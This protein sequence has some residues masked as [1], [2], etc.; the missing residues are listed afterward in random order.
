MAV[1]QLQGPRPWGKD[2][3]EGFM[4][5]LSYKQRKEI[6]EKELALKKTYYKILGEEA[7]RKGVIA[8]FA[9]REAEARA[10]VAEANAAEA[11]R[12]AKVHNANPLL[13]EQRMK[14]EAA[15]KSNQQELGIMRVMLQSS[16]QQLSSLN[17]QLQQTKFIHTQEKDRMN[18]LFNTFLNPD[19]AD[20]IR[21]A[22][23]EDEFA[24]MKGQA[25]EKL[26]GVDKRVTPV[27]E[28]FFKDSMGKLLGE[29]KATSISFDNALAA[30]GRGEIE[31]KKFWGIWRDRLEEEGYFLA[32][33]IILRNPTPQQLKELQKGYNKTDLGEQ[34][35]L[36][37]V[38]KEKK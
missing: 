29:P 33:D 11:E 5:M 1:T 23:G 36:D 3:M 20:P 8:P 26:T 4:T 24:M 2:M 31:T 37:K 14:A 32:G 17:Q 22:I 38:L 34:G 28:G 7:T 27:T 19:V 30:W 12:I 18:W 9:E 10:K 25:M 16:Q 35:A 6:A 13:M 15:A 21:E